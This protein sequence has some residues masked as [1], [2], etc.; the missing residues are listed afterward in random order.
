MNELEADSSMVM[1]SQTNINQVQA[2]SKDVSSIG[3]MAAMQQTM[4]SLQYTVNEL[5]EEKQYSGAG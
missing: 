1:D 4:T 2:N 5:I 3:L